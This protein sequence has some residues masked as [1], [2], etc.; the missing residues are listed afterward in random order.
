MRPR[1]TT[2]PLRRASAAWDRFWFAERSLVRL[3][4]F[5]ILVLALVL[6]DL[7]AYSSTALADAAAVSAGTFSKTWTPIYLFEVLGLEPIGIGTA[8]LVYAVALAA[9][10]LGILGLFTRASC[11]V[12]AVL[13]IYWTGL[14]YSTGKVHH[15]KVTLAFTLMALP[16]APVGARLSLD[17]FL[18][19]LRRAR[20]GGDPRAVP[21]RSGLAGVPLLLCQLTLAIGYGFSGVTKIAVS[22]FE[23]ANGYT[24]MGIL[25]RYDNVWSAAV[26]QS[27]ELCQLLSV[28][29]LVTQGTFPLVLLLPF[30]RWYYLPAAVAFHVTTWQAMDTGPYMT[31]WYL[32]IA[33]LPLER[34]PAW[35]GARPRSPGRWLFRLGVFLLPTALVLHVL[36]LYYPAWFAAFLVPP[37]AALLLPLAAPRRL[38]LLY[39]GERPGP[40]LLAAAVDALDW[41]GRIEL[42]PAGSGEWPGL[43]SA[44]GEPLRGL[45]AARALAWRL[46][47]ATPLAWLL[48]FSPG[49]TSAAPAR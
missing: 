3:A 19:R 8:R 48:G 28:G 21:E 17:A 33:F 39:D 46:P 45:A 34:I 5:R 9:T 47:L 26:T 2:G 27:P 49:R 31:L 43:R 18:A 1:G 41:S 4:V 37:A 35:V 23:W 38:L 10:C 42:R 16:L 7:I 30:L 13:C 40:R 14:V 15:D 29:A 25:V 6:A 11:L 36:F 24:L 22:G 44:T 20:A 12:A 32:L